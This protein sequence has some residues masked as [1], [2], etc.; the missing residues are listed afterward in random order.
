MLAIHAKSFPKVKK[1]MPFLNEVVERVKKGVLAQ[2]KT[3][4]RTNLKPVEYTFFCGTYPTLA[5]VV[6]R[7]CR[8]QVHHLKPQESRILRNKGCPISAVLLQH[9]QKSDK[10]HASSIGRFDVL[11]VQLRE[12][13]L[14]GRRPL[15]LVPLVRLGLALG[16]RSPAALFTTGTGTS[17][18]G[19]AYFCREAVL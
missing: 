12:D 14:H 9:L 6:A 8:E 5:V 7:A 13:V 1:S 17:T 16:H 18:G 19:G 4:G 11:L 15:R 2:L 10:G 3:A